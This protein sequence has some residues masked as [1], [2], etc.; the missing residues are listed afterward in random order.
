MTKIETFPHMEISSL[1]IK[2]IQNIIISSIVFW[3]T[4]DLI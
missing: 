4:L 1:L 3:K 2:T